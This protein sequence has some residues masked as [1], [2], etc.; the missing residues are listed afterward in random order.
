MIIQSHFIKTHKIEDS[1][2]VG[3]N[4]E[5]EGNWMKQHS[6]K[7]SKGFPLLLHMRGAVGL[8]GLSDVKSY[9]SRYPLVYNIFKRIWA[10]ICMRN[11]IFG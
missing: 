1:F 7:D 4:S 6:P 9:T 11:Q 10:S 5:E 3:L 8:V 2:L